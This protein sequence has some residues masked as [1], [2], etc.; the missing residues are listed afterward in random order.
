MFFL[1]LLGNLTC[2]LV[3]SNSFPPKSVGFIACHSSSAPALRV[4]A[5]AGDAVKEVHHIYA[6]GK[7]Q[8]LMVGHHFPDSIVVWLPSGKLT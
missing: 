7:M 5:G 1:F 4:H 6:S 3:K 2:L 8:H